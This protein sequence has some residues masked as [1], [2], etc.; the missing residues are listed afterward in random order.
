MSVFVLGLSTSTLQQQTTN[1]KQQQQRPQQRPQQQPQQQN[2]DNNKLFT[3]QKKTK[4]KTRQNNNKQK[5]ATL[6]SGFDCTTSPLLFNF[7]F[8]LPTLLSIPTWEVAIKLSPGV[9]PV[10][11]K[12]LQQ[13]CFDVG[14]HSHVYHSALPQSGVFATLSCSSTSAFDFGPEK[15]CMVVYP[16]GARGTHAVVSTDYFFHRTL[17]N[18]R[19]RYAS[20]GCHQKEHPLD[21][22]DQ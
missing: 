20:I 8:S 15:N 17:S 12:H 14:C 1:H 11:E 13:S 18:Y 22:L 16:I 10:R 3:Q 6:G 4:Q 21:S 2:N 9:S 19:L 5:T 7:G